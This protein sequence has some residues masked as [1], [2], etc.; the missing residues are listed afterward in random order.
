MPVEGAPVDRAVLHRAELC[1]GLGAAAASAGLAPAFLSTML[2]CVAGSSSVLQQ[3]V[4]LLESRRTSVAL[5]LAFVHACCGVLWCVA[6]Y[7][8]VLQCVAVRWRGKE[9]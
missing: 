7:C 9:S 2:Q 1:R 5:A 3:R 8:G 4:A 6:V